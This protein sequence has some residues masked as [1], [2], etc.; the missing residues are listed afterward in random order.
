MKTKQKPKQNKKIQTK[1]NP[2]SYNFIRIFFFLLSSDNIS[3]GLLPNDVYPSG[4][5]VPR[6]DSGLSV[7]LDHC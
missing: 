1:Q 5:V 4:T 2:N 6:L 3:E 7:K